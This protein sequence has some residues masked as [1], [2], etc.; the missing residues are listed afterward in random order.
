MKLRLALFFSLVSSV[1]N[2]SAEVPEKAI[3]FIL[4][5]HVYIQGVIADTIPV[6]LIYDTGAD[7]LYMDKD[8]MDLSTFGKLPL[9]K[10]QAKMGGAGNDGVQTVP[11][12]VDTIPL[13]MGDV[14]YKEH[15]TPIINLREILGRHTDGMIGNNAVFNKPLLVNYSDGYLLSLDSLA[16]GMLEGY[17]KLPAHFNDNRIDIECELKIDSAQ[18]LKGTFR[19]DLGCGSTIILTNAARKGIDLTG[20]PQ[21]ICYYSNMGVG[22]DGSDVNFRAESFKFL[23]ELY[24]IVISASYNTEGSLSDRAHLGIIGNDILCH[25]DL[26]ID[27]P[28]N[29]LYARRNCNADTSYQRSSKIQ[30]GYLDRTDI[31][32]GWIVSSMYEGGMAQKAGFEIGDEILSINGRSVKEISWEEQRKGLGLTGPTTYEV[33]KKSGEI[34]TYIL[35]IDKEII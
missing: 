33:K 12:I 27:A 24:N 2:I 30:M 18:C 3:P 21:A 20:K 15:I 8:Y 11:I 32:V 13:K 5:S 28:N 9:R 14:V 16:T 10:G 7:R 35:D 1:L 25:Y 34:V 26:I 29:A 23:D 4:D 19:L 17:T 22:G 6:S 31:A